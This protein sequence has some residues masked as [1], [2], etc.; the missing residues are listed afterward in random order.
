MSK[1]TYFIYSA[2][3]RLIMLILAAVLG[4]VLLLVVYLLPVK[5]MMQNASSSSEVLSEEGYYPV[6]WGEEIGSRLDNFTD[7]LMIQNAIAPSTGSLLEDAVSVS[8]MQYGDSI[9]P[10]EDLAAQTSGQEGGSLHEYMR[11]WHG[12]LIFLKPLLL[13]T[14][15]TGIRIL[16]AVL[17]TALIILV[18]FLM[19]KRGLTTYI[20]PFVLSWTAI[21]PWVLPWSM[22]LSTMYYIAMTGTAV[23]LMFYPFIRRH[24]CMYFMLLGILTSYFD[25]LT[26]PLISFGLPLIF[27]L[28]LD[29]QE[30]KV[31][32]KHILLLMI[33]LGFHWGLGYGGMWLL[34][35]I[36]SEAVLHNG[37]ISQAVGAAIYRSSTESEGAG[38]TVTALLTWIENIKR[39][40]NPAFLAAILIFIAVLCAD[41]VRQVRAGAFCLQIST[42]VP[43]LLTA[44]LPP[45][46]YALIKNH[47]FVHPYLTYRI[48]W[49][50]I[51][52]GMCMLRE[53]YYDRTAS[54]AQRLLK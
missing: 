43:F 24:L 49:I 50:S 48:L 9:S 51:F 2:A 53:L 10:I 40:F 13:I 23:L 39:V 38:V 27:V 47:S 25:Y 31:S 30:K 1:T 17:Q 44:L 4:L 36:I 15:H 22:Q 14:D 52:A 16:N 7:A 33:T 11:Y 3:K 29:R 54:Y 42:A 26:W 6:K 35:W 8:H 37:A 5:P 45:V 18:L 46:W 28:L 12:Y 19:R 32:L 20:L 41:I 21:A 34:K